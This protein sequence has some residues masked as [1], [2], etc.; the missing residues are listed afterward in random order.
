MKTLLQRAV[1]GAAALAAVTSSAWADCP[2]CTADGTQYYVDGLDGDDTWTGQCEIL[3]P[4]TCTPGPCC[5]P[6]HTIQAGLEIPE[7][8]AGDVVNIL[9]GEYVTASTVTMGGDCI[10]VRALGEVVLRSSAHVGLLVLSAT[11]ARVEGITLQGSMGQN[12]TQLAVADSHNVLIQRCRFMN[13][14]YG[15]GIHGGGPPITNVTVR[16]CL[17]VGNFVYGA[18]ITAV[19]GPLKIGSPPI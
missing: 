3:D 11:G 14:R 15:V 4:G 5:G 1:I 9:P 18:V 12:A 13:G 16:E 6:K 8:A 17:F 10:T 19:P 7:L 2:C